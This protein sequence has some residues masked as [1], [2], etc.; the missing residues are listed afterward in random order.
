MYFLVFSFKQSP[1]CE[2]K[3]KK[4]NYVCKCY[5]LGF[6]C[7][8][9]SNN[10]NKVPFQSHKIRT[11]NIIKEHRMLFVLLYIYIKTKKYNNNQ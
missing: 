11:V 3:K 6:A 1:N 8:L 7:I 9:R 5:R 4:T 2:R 10:Y